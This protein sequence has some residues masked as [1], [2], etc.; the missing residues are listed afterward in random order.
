M[1]KTTIARIGMILAATLGFSACSSTSSSTE[2]KQ[3]SESVTSK[4]KTLAVSLKSNPTTGFSWECSIEDGSIAKIASDTYKQDSA[5]KDMVGVGGLQT[6][7]IKCVKEGTTDIT[8]TYRRPWK[9][10]ETGE[11]RR[12]KLSVDEKLRGTLNFY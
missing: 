1:K 3:A 12:A 6:F 7:V 5:P 2:P 10:G 4:N 11:T 9:G 8:F